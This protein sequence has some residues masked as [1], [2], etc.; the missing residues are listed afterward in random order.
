MWSGLQNRSAEAR[1]IEAVNMERIDTPVEKPYRMVRR[2]SR[3][4]L[5]NQT[6]HSSLIGKMS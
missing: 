3:M 2:L 1:I 4:A 6:G 5:A